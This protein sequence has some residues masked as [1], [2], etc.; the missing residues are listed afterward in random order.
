RRNIDALFGVVYSEGISLR[1]SA[2]LGPKAA[3]T[4]VADVCQAAL[5]TQTP[6]IEL[7]K[8]HD[9]VSAVLSAAEIEQLAGIDTQ[10]AA[11]Q[12]MC[13]AVILQWEHHQSTLQTQE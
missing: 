10:I 1:L 11:C 5:S 3:A 6:V 7:L 2:L 13:S 12:P 4:I 8:Q 9:Q